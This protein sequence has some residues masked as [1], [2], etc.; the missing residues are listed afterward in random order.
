VFRLPCDHVRCGQLQGDPLKLSGSGPHA[1]RRY[2]AVP[3]P[4]RRVPT[5]IGPKIEM[6]TTTST[7]ELGLV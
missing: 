4:H 5:R 7:Q 2:S 3:S 1:K 6:H